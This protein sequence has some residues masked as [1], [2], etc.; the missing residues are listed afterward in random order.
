MF[1]SLIVFEMMLSDARPR[2]A[3]NALSWDFIN[4]F[5]VI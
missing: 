2:L 4:K 1:K 5:I 3:T